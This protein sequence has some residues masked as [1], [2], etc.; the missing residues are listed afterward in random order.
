MST[1]TLERRGDAAR[2]D[3][4]TGPSAGGRATDASGVLNQPMTRSALLCEA[5]KAHGFAVEYEGGGSTY[6]VRTS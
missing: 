3:D 5:L 6:L 4:S 1:Q 2:S